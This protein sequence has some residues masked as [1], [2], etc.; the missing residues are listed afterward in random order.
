MRRTI[1]AYYIRF[2]FLLSLC[3]NAYSEKAQALSS[4]SHNDFHTHSTPLV[5][6][7]LFSH[8]REIKVAGVYWL[9]D[10]LEKNLDFS[11]NKETPENPTCAQLGY[12]SAIIYPYQ[13]CTRFLAANK[14]YCYK[15]CS[16]AEDFKYDA[17]NC[18][19]G[20]ILGTLQKLC[21]NKSDKCTCPEGYSFEVNEETCLQKG[22][23]YAF[24]SKG[25]AGEMLCGRCREVA[26]PVSKD[27]GRYA[28]KTTKPASGRCGSYCAECSSCVEGGSNS[29]TGSTSGC[30]S[31]QVMTSSCRDCDGNLR[32]S[33]RQ[34]GCDSG[35]LDM[36]NYWCNGALKCWLPQK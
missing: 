2:F 25:A 9:P 19:D 17:S 21:G 4:L 33:C 20:A 18:T 13:V 31:D 14:L 11:G 27:C 34:K 30:G 3:L 6:Q 16:C 23:G 7:P 28:C 32:F 36:E 15:N 22:N 26:C 5:L 1:M 8:R 29:C 12:L 10:Y 35:L 24:E